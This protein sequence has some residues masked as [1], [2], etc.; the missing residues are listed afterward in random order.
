MQHLTVRVAWH[1]SAWN[2]TVC[3]NPSG[4]PYCLDLDRIRAERDDRYE[5]AIA[6]R[7]FADIDLQR[8][9]WLQLLVDNGQNPMMGY[10]G[11]G[12]VMLPLLGLTG[13]KEA[14]ESTTPAPWVAFGWGL[15]VT[16]LVAYFVRFF[17]RRKLFW[18]S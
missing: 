18:R 3:Q 17:S 11:Y 15:I 10:V 16:L 4:N 9:R 2:G 1:D 12:M 6:G 7:D 5:G 14:I 13:I 8:R